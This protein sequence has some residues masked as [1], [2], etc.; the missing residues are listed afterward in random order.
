MFGAV[1]SRETAI[2]AKLLKIPLNSGVSGRWF[3]M[4]T[5]QNAAFSG[6]SG[7][8]T[9]KILQKKF[10]PSYQIFYGK[11]LHKISVIFAAFHAVIMFSAVAASILL[12]FAVRRL[13]FE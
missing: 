2:W 7:L 11:L 9:K 1:V 3:A 10:L 5:A 12:F 8:S 13:F 6:F 4:L